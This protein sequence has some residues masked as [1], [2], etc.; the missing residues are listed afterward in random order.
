MRPC[1]SSSAP[2]RAILGARSWHDS[3][4]RAAIRPFSQP[5]WASSL[6]AMEQNSRNA[7]SLSKI[8][9]KIVLAESIPDH[10][11]VA[12]TAIPEIL[13]TDRAAGVKM[14]GARPGRRTALILEQQRVEAAADAHGTGH[15]AHG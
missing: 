6:A 1:L 13:T 8:S 5:P 14:P 4:T 10:P 7:S 9:A 11:R 3:G 12:R 2:C 15:P